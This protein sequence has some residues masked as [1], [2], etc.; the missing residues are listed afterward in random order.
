M[1]RGTTPTLIFK[2]PYTADQIELGYITF[3]RKGIVFM[4]IPFTDSRISVDDYSVSLTFS[5]EDTL[6]FNSMTVYAVQLR[7]LLEEGLA[8]A[9]TILTVPVDSILKNGFI[10]N[11]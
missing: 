4:D 10:A 2:T 9:S 11:E 6:R 1:I 3:A 7:I 5:Q 8:V